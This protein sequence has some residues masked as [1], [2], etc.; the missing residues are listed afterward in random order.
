ME[1]N[2]S[3]VTI[4][5]N[6]SKGL[7][8]TM[9]SLVGQSD[10]IYEHIIIDGESRDNTHELVENYKNKV[11]YQVIFVSESD[12][13]IYNAMNKGVQRATGGLIS[14]L[15][16]GDI[17]FDN[18]CSIVKRCYNE[19]LPPFVLY[20]GG[21]V[22]F[23]RKNLNKDLFLKYNSSS[24]LPTKMSLFHPS[25]FISKELYDDF[26]LYN[27]KYSIA[28]DFDLLRRMYLGGALFIYINSLLVKMEAGGISTLPSKSYEIALQMNMIINSNKSKYYQFFYIVKEISIGYLAW[29]KRK[30]VH[31][32][33]V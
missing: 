9:Q 5:K 18:T 3:I 11:D 13:G 27:E 1:F 2:L 25:V 23:P 10:Y 21:R 32:I 29:L 14:I 4:C 26:G 19:N 31:I 20:G 28:S 8:A 24:M 12:D 17:F 16:S 15:N 33:N 22:F 6:N 30:I 7:D